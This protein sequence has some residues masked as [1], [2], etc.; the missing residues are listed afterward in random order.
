[1]LLSV[2]ASETKM[3]NVKKLLLELSD[4]KGSA[5]MLFNAWTSFARHFTPPKPRH[6]LFTAPWAGRG[7]SHST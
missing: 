3:E 1:M 4:G 2:F 5:L 6:D 7:M